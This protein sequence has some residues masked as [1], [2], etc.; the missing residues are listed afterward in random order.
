MTETVLRGEKISEHRE[1]E[2]VTRIITPGR[3]LSGQRPVA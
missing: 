2:A 1:T 3:A